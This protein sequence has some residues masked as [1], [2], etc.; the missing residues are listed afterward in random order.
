MT[1]TLDTEHPTDNQIIRPLVVVGVD[2]S[3][4]SSQAVAWAA[5]YITRVGG[6]L[7]L[8]TAWHWPPSYG[9]PLAAIDFDIEGAAR[10]LVEKAATQVSL[11]PERIVTSV[12]EGQP[13]QRLV[14]ASKRSDVLVVGSRGHGG[15][16]GLLL[17]SVSA[18]CV[19][20]AHC[21]VIVIRPA[22]VDREAQTE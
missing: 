7:E 13:A 10:D 8:V 14:D 6:T 18:H 1:L 2:G 4:A 15:F 3:E 12:V 21:P 17:G 20:Q 9:F 22:E 5:T 11:P 16:S 19:H